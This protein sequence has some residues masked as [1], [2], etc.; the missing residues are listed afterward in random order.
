LI[1]FATDKGYKVVHKENEFYEAEDEHILAL[2]EGMASDKLGDKIV[3]NEEAPT[4]AEGTDKAIKLLHNQA[5]Q[6]KTGFFLMVEEEG[7]DSGSHIN[8]IDFV[9]SHL[10]NLDDA[11]EVAL[12]F[13]VKDR[14]TLVL[15]LADHE[16]G[17]L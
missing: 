13:A 2:F 5:K 8:R 16:T 4:L 11:I 3:F 15:V 7:V 14:E 6:N 9:T 17:G 1:D 12:D 10:K